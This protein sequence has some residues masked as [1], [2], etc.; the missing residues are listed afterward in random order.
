MINKNICLCKSRLTLGQRRIVDGFSKTIRDIFKKQGKQIIAFMHK[1][2]LFGKLE[3]HFSKKRKPKEKSFSCPPINSPEWN[4]LHGKLFELDEATSE[5]INKSIDSEEDQAFL[6]A[7]IHGLD[8][9]EGMADAFDSWYMKASNMAGNEA[10]K[11]IGVHVVFNLKESRMIKEFQNRG[12]EITGNISKKTLKDFQQV[13]YDTYLEE[14]IT[15]YEVAKRIEGMFEETYANRAIAIART[16][17]GIA[18]NKTEFA[19]YKNNGVE[20][21][22]WLATLDNRTRQ[23]HQDANG[24][25]RDI[26]EPFDIDTRDGGTEELMFPLDPEASPENLCNCRCAFVAL[27]EDNN[28]PDDNEAWT[29]DE[30]A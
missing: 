18:S 3:S 29:G 7:M 9:D 16:E 19:V 23:S 1:K 21:K 12:T 11:K 5:I 30:V 13:L 27:F 6:D 2:N 24:Q 8:I 20:K 28:I 4:K 17:T 10:L 15:P 26:D 25:V 22:K 14:G